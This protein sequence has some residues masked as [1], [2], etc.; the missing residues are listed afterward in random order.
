MTPQWHLCVDAVE[1]LRQ[2]ARASGGSGSLLAAASAFIKE[3]ERRCSE[4][5]QATLHTLRFLL[6][7]ADQRVISIA[8][9]HSLDHGWGNG[10]IRPPCKDERIVTE[11]SRGQRAQVIQ[12]HRRNSSPGA[13]CA[14]Q[15]AA[16]PP[17]HTCP[18]PAS[19]S[20]AAWYVN[21]LSC[22][23]DVCLS[24]MHVIT[25]FTYIHFN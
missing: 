14:L 9:L 23:M 15:S 25:G 12:R 3:K 4:A 17:S 11:C 1:F 21:S 19:S 6:W 8:L 24:C 22:C 16:E 10:I 5:A 2:Q 18:C 13:V 20:S 7:A